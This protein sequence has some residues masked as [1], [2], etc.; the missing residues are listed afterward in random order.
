MSIRRARQHL[1]M[2]RDIG[3]TE[4]EAFLGNWL[5][6]SFTDGDQYDIEVVFADEIS[7][8]RRA[9]EVDDDGN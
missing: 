5:V 2:I 8:N 1:P 9:L 6:Q 4:T 3:R 7:G